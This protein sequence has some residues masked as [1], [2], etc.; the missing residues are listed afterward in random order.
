MPWHS[1]WWGL[2]N[3]TING[4]FLWNSAKKGQIL[5]KL[6]RHQNVRTRPLYSPLN[7][8]LLRFYCV[9]PNLPN[10]HLWATLKCSSQSLKKGL[11]NQGIGRKMLFS[12]E[13]PVRVW[14]QTHLH[15]YML[16]K[17][18]KWVTCD[19][20][21]LCVWPYVYLNILCGSC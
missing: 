2:K 20:L 12:M 17:F 10:Y 18:W 4:N 6:N 3:L 5:K 7:S 19:R 9:R 1:F 15:N 21:I 11:R 13:Q 8:K 14:V 16:P